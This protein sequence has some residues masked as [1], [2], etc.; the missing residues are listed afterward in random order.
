MA[1]TPGLYVPLDMN[2]LRDPDIRRAGPDAELLFIRSL[3]HSKSGNTDGKIWDYDLDVVA[4]G[5]K[6]VPARVNALV[7]EG[8]WIV[9]DGGWRIRSWGKWNMTQ[10][11]I[12]EDK[13]RRR[14][15]AALT[16]HERW[17]VKEGKF[18]DECPLCSE[19]LERSQQ[20]SLLRV[21]NGSLREEKGREEK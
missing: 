11:E 1:K 9:E 19:S 12:R 3:A 20:R 21:A 2:Y 17:H 6:G 14:A 16:N 10:A 4:V 8:L 18:D 13:Q 7:R 15:G 5:L